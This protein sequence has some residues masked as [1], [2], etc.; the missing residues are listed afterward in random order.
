MN[1]TNLQHDARAFLIILKIEAIL[2]EGHQVVF[3]ECFQ[4]INEGQTVSYLSNDPS[5]YL[6]LQGLLNHLDGERY[7]NYIATSLHKILEFLHV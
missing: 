7:A 6:W 3:E 5:Y 4:N 1:L 2:I